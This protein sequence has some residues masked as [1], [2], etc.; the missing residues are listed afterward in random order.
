MAPIL[1]PAPILICALK[2]NGSSASPCV[3]SA[4]AQAKIAQGGTAAEHACEHACAVPLRSTIPTRTS[5]HGYASR[6][7]LQCCKGIWAPFDTP[8]RPR[9]FA[10]RASGHLLRSP[11]NQPNLRTG[12]YNKV[13][14]Q[15]P[16]QPSHSCA[17]CGSRRHK[18]AIR[19]TRRLAKLAKEQG[20][21][22]TKCWTH[23]AFATWSW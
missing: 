8:P 23:L 18:T 13:S 4:T 19:S 5:R 17:W 6:G 15:Q 7:R 11:Y 3:M 14:W 22:R 2:I 9:A 21:K 16:A 20:C 12:P 1:A 10:L